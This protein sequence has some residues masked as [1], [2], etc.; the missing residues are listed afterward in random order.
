MARR[1]RGLAETARGRESL[2]TLVVAAATAVGATGAA[3]ARL[4]DTQQTLELVAVTGLSEGAIERWRV[5]SVEDDSPLAEAVRTLQPVY[6]RGG[7]LPGELSTGSAVAVPLTVEGHPIGVLGLDYSAARVFGDEERE[8]FES[9]AASAAGAL[10]RTLRSEAGERAGHLHELAA[11]LAALRTREELAEAIV[12]EGAAA[13]GAGAASLGV[14][15]PDRRELRLVAAHGYPDEVLALFDPL[16]L[17]FA[18]P[19]TDAVRTGDLIMIESPEALDESYPDVRER[20]GAPADRAMVAIPLAVGGVP[21]GA[22][23]FGFAAERL[24]DDDT[25]AFMLALA[26][27]AAQ[28]L[29]HVE[30]AR[31]HDRTSRLQA[32]TA[33]LARSVTQADVARVIIDEAVAALG[34]IGG[35]VA[36][37]EPVGG[38]LATIAVSGY[39]DGF[40]ERLRVADED[41][42]MPVAVAGS[43]GDPVLIPSLG[44]AR[45]EWPVAA[46]EFGALGHRAAAAVPLRSHQ[47][48]I[49]AVAFTWREEQPFDR[50]DVSFLVVLAG[51]CSEALER[52]RLYEASEQARTRLRH[53]LD[54]LGEAVIQVDAQLRV[55]Y[56]NKEAVQ[57]FGDPALAGTTL[58]DLW[59]ELGLRDLVRSQLAGAAQ[60]VDERTP[61]VDGRTM[62]VTAMVEDGEAILV[63][64]D[65]S[66]RERQERAER[67]FVAN[68]AHELR[69]P[70]AAIATA[71]DALERGAKDLPAERDFYIAGIVSEIDRLVRLSDALLL[72]ARVQADPGMMRRERVELEPIIT[73]VAARLEVRPGVRV[74][75]KCTGEAI[76]GEQALVEGALANLTR[77]ASRHTTSGSITLSSRLAGDRVVIEV[78][79]TGTGMADDVRERAPARFFRGGERS[80]DG[81]GLGLA[82][83]QEM[84][85]A[86]DGELTI[87]SRRGGG[88]VVKLTLGAA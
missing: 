28:A 77:N 39:P 11:R 45:S 40:L 23:A 14:L 42:L 70:L 5:Q 57:L 55:T 6:A 25:C 73:D 85:K 18:A 86:L 9:L 43:S 87:S 80:R 38:T 79:D 56:A 19:L 44:D 21:F 8:R 36:V 62:E 64:R 2:R 41:V 75:V 33:E 58:P 29:D 48:V 74:V 71:A 20:R 78:A 1:G 31:L 51:L 63:L 7:L 69:T 13:L 54:R 52:A 10:D 72:L 22:L 59:P 26:R 37:V 66:R 84:V 4:S 30:A 67:E 65:V 3:L 46:R 82:I 12:V 68:A 76:R 15:D 17:D 83:A 50:E 88:T 27:L 49:G 35:R 16:P 53:V 47:G 24:F 32:V 60:P 61:L 34:A 81:F